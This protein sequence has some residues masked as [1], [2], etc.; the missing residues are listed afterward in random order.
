MAA[1]ADAEGCTPDL[2]AVLMIRIGH[3]GGAQA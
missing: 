3:L 2:N 1:L